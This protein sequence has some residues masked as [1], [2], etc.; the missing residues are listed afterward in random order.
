MKKVK[1]ETCISILQDV[2][3]FYPSFVNRNETVDVMSL[4]T[5]DFNDLAKYIDETIGV[6]AGGK[7]IKALLDGAGPKNSTINILCAFLLVKKGLMT[8]SELK[9][10]T[11]VSDNRYYVR[12]YFETNSV[13]E[14]SKQTAKTEIDSIPDENPEYSEITQVPVIT[15]ND[16]K[17][18]LYGFLGIAVVLL[19]IFGISRATEKSSSF[20]ELRIS[21]ADESDRY[22]KEINLSYDLKSNEHLI[23]TRISFMSTPIL[24]N[25]LKGTVTVTAPFPGFFPIKLYSNENVY[26]VKRVLLKSRGWQ[27]FSGNKI[28]LLANEFM[29]DSVIHLINTGN[30]QKLPNDDY[31]TFFNIYRNFNVSGD[32]FELEADIKNPPNEGSP[33]AHDISVDIRGFE[34]PVTFNF[35]SPDALKHANMIVGDTDFKVGDKQKV[36]QKLGILFPDWQHL[37]VICKNKRIKIMLDEQL[38]ID[39]HYDGQIGQ[40]VGLQFFFKGSGYVKNVKLNGK[41][42]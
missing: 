27:G 40:I 10:G 5:S 22:P 11:N 1:K 39:E 32:S 37:T 31:Y 28:P 38:I 17:P 35:L 24:L 14:N 30:V 18:Y 2:F 23:N 20:P 8:L 26:D 41:S 19:V 9:L 29:L 36:L 21:V 34:N 7:S 16:T 25:K 12:R 15:P 3:G 42:I 4:S 33:W 13:G 6:T